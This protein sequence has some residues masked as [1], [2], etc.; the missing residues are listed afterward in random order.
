MR[1]FGDVMTPEFDVGAVASAIGLEARLWPGNC[2]TV[3][4]KMVKAGIVSGR[5]VYGLYFGPVEPGS[6]FFQKPV[7]RHGWI[8]MESGLI[9]DPTR[10]VFENEPPYIYVGAPSSEYDEGAN[11][12][13]SARMRKAPDFDPGKSKLVVPPGEAGNVIAALLGFDRFDGE[14]NT[15]Q[16]FWL[17]NLPSNVLGELMA[18][19][20][21]AL[22]EMGCKGFIPVDNYRMYL[23][24]TSSSSSSFS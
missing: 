5:A 6:M 23:E 21:R 7:V 14:I 16:A 13:R 12:L 15:E 2:Y 24:A 10:W 19:L 1:A 17:G 9:V 3:S 18:P 11:L 8:K 22:V 20:Y 4:C